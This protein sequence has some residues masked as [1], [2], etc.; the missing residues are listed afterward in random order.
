[1]NTEFEFHVIFTCHKIFFFF[2]YFPPSHLVVQKP[3]AAELVI[4]THFPAPYH[5]IAD[6]GIEG[7]RGTG[8][9]Q[10]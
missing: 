4:Y 5:S 9:I 8:V 1:M 6:P 10:W 7:G 2:G 3:W